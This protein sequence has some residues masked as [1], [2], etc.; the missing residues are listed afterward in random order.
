MADVKVEP[1]AKE[2]GI[3]KFTIYRLPK[4]TPGIYRYGKALRVNVEELRAW[5]RQ[6][7]NNSAS[8]EAK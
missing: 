1:A 5:A 8:L 4:S 6:E 2:L 3:S 7:K